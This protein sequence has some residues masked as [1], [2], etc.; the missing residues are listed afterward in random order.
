VRDLREKGYSAPAIRY[1]LLGAHYRAKLNFTFE[2]VDQAQAALDRLVDLV[3]RLEEAA[4]TSLDGVVEHEL[5]AREAAVDSQWRDALADD[6]NLPQAMGRLF[7][8]VREANA[9]LDRGELGEEEAQS[10]LGLLRQ[11]DRVLNCVSCARRERG[12]TL[13]PQ[14]EA[15][16]RARQRARAEGNWKESDRLRQEL[17]ELG[18]AVEDTKSGQ[19]WKRVRPRQADAVTGR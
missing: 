8:W 15:L 5:L 13:S 11:A 10:A 14:E 19:R 17:L 6:L 12:E 16:T 4:G 9:G 3:E 1:A 2:G 7:D 18:L